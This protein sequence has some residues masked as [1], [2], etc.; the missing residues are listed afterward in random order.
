MGYTRWGSDD[1]LAL[2]PPSH[3]NIR[4]LPPRGSPAGG[5]HSTALDLV[6]FATALESH[7]LL[8]AQYTDLI[9]TAKVRDYAY[10]FEDRRVNGKRVIGHGGGA[11][12]MNAELRI[13]PE[14][15]YV[16]VVLTN[17]DPPFASFLARD[18][19]DLFTRL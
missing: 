15:G 2:G 12:G 17:Y 19:L 6:R 18:I 11:P 3:S 10:G 1:V 14:L 9:T 5:G 4:T 16:I 8:N 7:D 13:I